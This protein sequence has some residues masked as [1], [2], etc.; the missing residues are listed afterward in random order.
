MK[1][2]LQ[3][4]PPSSWPCDDRH[5]R[6]T[7]SEW[8]TQRERERDG[9]AERGGL[10]AGCLT[11]ASRLWAVTVLVGLFSRLKYSAHV[12]D[13]KFMKIIEGKSLATMQR[14]ARKT[15]ETLPTPPTQVLSL[16]SVALLP[17]CLPGGR[18]ESTPSPVF[19]V[20]WS[21]VE[22]LRAD[23]IK[24]TDDCSKGVRSKRSLQCGAPLV[25]FFALCWEF[26]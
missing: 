24:H 3:V 2:L 15:Q 11:A 18:H 25:S 21:A 22:S 9:D 17:V 16:S 5:L 12:R 20:E 14:L 1:F 7:E 8:E 6:E 26:N 23:R 19:Q 4:T 13:E 10:G